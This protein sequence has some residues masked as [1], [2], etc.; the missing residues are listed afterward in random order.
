MLVEDGLLVFAY[1]FQGPQALAA[2]P[3][4]LGERRQRVQHFQVAPDHLVHARPQ[5]LDHDF[6]R[7]RAVQWHLAAQF[8][9][10]HL[11]DGRGRQ[12]FLVEGR[13]HL[14]GGLAVGLLDDVAR[15]APVERRHAVL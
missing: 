15:D 3:V 14:F 4:V 9:G 8:G 10:V 7:L 6:A 1:H 13:E 11:G 2:L 12:R 5:H